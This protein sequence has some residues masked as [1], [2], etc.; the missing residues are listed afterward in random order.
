MEADNLAENN[1]ARVGSRAAL[2]NETVYKIWNGWG[3]S[4]PWRQKHL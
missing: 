1:M 3:K 2:V 4:Y